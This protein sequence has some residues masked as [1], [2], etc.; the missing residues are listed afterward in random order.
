MRPFMF[1]ELAGVTIPVT[2]TLDTVT[3]YGEYDNPVPGTGPFSQT[4]TTNAVTGTPGGGTGPYTFSWQRVSGD[5]S[6]TCDTPTAASTTWH[7]TVSR[8]VAKNATWA[9]L[10]L[11]SLSSPAFSALVSVRVLYNYDSGA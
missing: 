4:V 6:I 5:S 1:N 9:L 10:V 11:D 3:A 2:V 8:N 7:A